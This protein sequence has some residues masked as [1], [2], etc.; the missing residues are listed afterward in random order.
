MIA[1]RVVRPLALAALAALLGACGTGPSPLAAPRA[2]EALAARAIDAT[3]RE[4]AKLLDKDGDGLV[5]ELEGWVSGKV[6]GES[7]ANFAGKGRPG[8]PVPTSTL[9]R[10]L[11]TRGEI[12]IYGVAGGVGPDGLGVSLTDAAIGR[13]AQGLA[14][15]LAGDPLT[16][17]DQIPARL[18]EVRRYGFRDDLDAVETFRVGALAT[19]I[20]ERLAKRGATSR[21]KLVSGEMHLRTKYRV[22][23]SDSSYL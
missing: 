6:E 15:V 21:V 20:R 17:G 14:A 23:L 12:L 9:E 11:A 5:V 1:N 4:V 10:A 2:A 8:K 13:L 18:K 3:P 7:F 22:V 19:E 16:V